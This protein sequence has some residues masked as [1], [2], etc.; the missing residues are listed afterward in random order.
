MHKLANLLW[1]ISAPHPDPFDAIAGNDTLYVTHVAQSRATQE[2]DVENVLRQVIRRALSFARPAL[3]AQGRPVTRLTFLWDQVYC[4][5]SVNYT[6]DT[7]IHDAR[8]ITICSFR[9]IDEQMHALAERDEANWE[10]Q[11]TRFSAV[12]YRLIAQALA[13]SELTVLPPHITITYLD[14]DRASC[15][16]KEIMAAAKVIKIKPAPQS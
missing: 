1:E 7:M 3:M 4:N 10:T 9:K 2:T 11:T 6:D 14:E 8:D 16:D 5:L 12:M 15:T 13:T